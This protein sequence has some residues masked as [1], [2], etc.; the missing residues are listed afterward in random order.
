MIICMLGGARLYVILGGVRLYVILSG[1]YGWGRFICFLGE[2]CLVYGI[3]GNSLGFVQTVF[4]LHVVD[5]FGG[6]KKAQCNC[7]PSAFMIL[8]CSTFSNPLLWFMV[9]S[10]WM[11]IFLWFNGMFFS[12]LK[13]K[14]LDWNLRLHI[15]C[16]K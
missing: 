8:R 11:I 15:I 10:N 13:I 14:N 3:L 1:A 6:I 16:L 2:L 7:I 12:V 4:N 9:S 5:L